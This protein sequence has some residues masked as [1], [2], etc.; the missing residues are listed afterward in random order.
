MANLKLHPPGVLNEKYALGRQTK[1][2]WQYRVKRRTDEVIQSIHKYYPS[3]KDSISILDIGAAEGLML[4][5]IKKEFP[6]AR[7]VGLEYSQ[8]LIN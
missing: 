3:K 8:K 2:A 5:A 4:S 1:R 6:E 7:C